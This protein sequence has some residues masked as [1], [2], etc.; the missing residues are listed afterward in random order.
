[1]DTLKKFRWLLL[2]KNVDPNLQGSY[3]LNPSSY[4]NT[5]LHTLIANEDEQDALK[6]IELLE[7]VFMV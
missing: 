6:L 1:M 2:E 4:K 7:P 5:A 3:E